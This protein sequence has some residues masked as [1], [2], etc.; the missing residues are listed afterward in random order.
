MPGNGS[1]ERVRKGIGEELGQ[2]LVDEA[3]RNVSDDLFHDG[4]HEG[5]AFWSRALE[6]EVE[7]TTAIG[8]ATSSST[9]PSKYR[10][11]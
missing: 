11:S 5:P 3:R 10:Q 4:R 7:R 8:R 1:I 6:R 2:V 9:T